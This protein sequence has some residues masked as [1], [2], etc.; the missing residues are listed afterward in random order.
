MAKFYIQS[1]N[2]KI[3]KDGRH[4]LSTIMTVFRSKIKRDKEIVL[5]EEVAISEA[6]FIG[7]LTKMVDDDPGYVNLRKLRCVEIPDIKTP[8]LPL[9]LE[10]NETYFINTKQVLDLINLPGEEKPEL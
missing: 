9:H 1:G 5:G 10:E 4:Y 6:G 2:T 7:D 3:V 8:L